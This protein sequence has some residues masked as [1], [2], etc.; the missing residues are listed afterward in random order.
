MSLQFARNEPAHPNTS[1]GCVHTCVMLNYLRES[2]REYFRYRC[3]I[4]S[5]YLSDF[6]GR[7]LG[8]M[9]MDR[10]AQCKP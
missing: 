9:M 5:S 8:S 6:E 1:I 10:A 4:A 3:V 7:S 2:F